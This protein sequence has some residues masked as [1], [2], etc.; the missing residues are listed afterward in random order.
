MILNEAAISELAECIDQDESGNSSYWRDALKGFQY[1]NGEVLGVLGAEGY[2]PRQSIVHQLGHYAL[3]APFQ[4]IGHR[5][6]HFKEFLR[7]GKALTKRR[8]SQFDLCMMRQVLTLSLL[9][10]YLSLGQMRQPFVVIGDGWGVMTSLILSCM[11]RAKVVVVNL[12]KMLLVDLVY[13]RRYLTEVDVCVA[14]DVPQ[15]LS[16]LDSNRVRVIGIRADDLQLIRHG[17]VGVAINI[18]S[19]QEMDP[20]VI[21]SYFEALRRSANSETLF[22]CC[23]RVEKTLPDGTEVRF[24]DYPWNADDRVLIDELC[25][26][27]QFYY[28]W[29]PPFY[30]KYAGPIRHRLT[31]INKMQ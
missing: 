9:A 22:Y 8:G 26:W 31:W 24:E 28:Q 21:A 17:P 12:T 5:F 27:H 4:R 18:A 6:T 10:E 16:S 30:R 11:P 25:S 1:S 3:L 29:R 14:H 19:M 13:T 7:T 20:Q 2:T 15:Y 23:N